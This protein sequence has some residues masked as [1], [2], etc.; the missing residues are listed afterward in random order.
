MS[1]ASDWS[2]L[3]G[4]T[5]DRSQ[6][7]DP[8]RPS[9]IAAP[10]GGR[11]RLVTRTG[12]VHVSPLLGRTMQTVRTRMTQV[13]RRVIVLSSKR[14]THHAFLEGILHGKRYLYDNNVSVKKDGLLDVNRTTRSDEPA[15]SPMIYVASFERKYDLPELYREPAYAELEARHKSPEGPQRVIYLR[16]PLNTLASTYSAHL[17]TDYFSHFGYVLANVRQWVNT[18]RYLLEARSGGELFIYANRFWSEDTYRQSC[19]EALDIAEYRRSNRLSKFGGG[20]NTFFEE[21]D[22]AITPDVLNSRYRTYASDEKY[23]A[24]IAD[25]RE[26]FAAFFEHVGDTAMLEVLRTF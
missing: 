2:G 26:L 1:I 24:L 16:D 17:K 4:T 8:V 5:T 9:R 22:K 20:G 11:V 23:A 13:D 6:L 25:N 12:P 7:E 3:D 18:A 19:L 15:D 10:S 14:S 21:K